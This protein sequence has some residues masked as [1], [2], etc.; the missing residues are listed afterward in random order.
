MPL[1]LITFVVAFVIALVLYPPFIRALRR[2]KAG[3]VIQAELPD[4]HQ[5]KAGTPTAGGVLFVALAI[6]GGVLA[7]T[8]GHRGATPAAAG[9]VIGG[10]IGFADDRSKLMVGTRGIP[11]RLKFPIQLVLAV[12]VAWLAITQGASH[13]LFLPATPWVIF[14]LAV[15]AIVATANAVNLT[16]GMDGLAGGLSVIAVAALVL[17]LPGAPAGEKAAAISLCG[18]LA[19][20]LVFNRYPARVFM[21]DTGSL[22]I[23]FALAAMAIQQGVMLLLPLLGLVFVLETLS[24]IIQ[25]AFFKATG[26][27][28]IFTMT[29][30]H[31]TFHHK[32]WSEN[33]IALTF[34]GAGLVSALA[35]VGVARLAT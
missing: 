3:Q 28:R 26:G 18:A 2:I 16:D 14:P 33:R 5:K 22:A 27:R 6:L 8:A 23:G 11:A 1:D 10:L 15:V 7:S 25:V 29:P 12:P 21:G 17:L 32:G 4:S 30:I 34:W 35:A 31:Y 13:Q 19:A 9:L 20:F 24:V